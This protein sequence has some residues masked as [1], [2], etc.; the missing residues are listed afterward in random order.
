[1]MKIELR[2]DKVYLDGY[3]NAVGRDSRPIPDRRGP[4]VEQVVPGTFEKALSRGKPIELRIN[5]GRALGSTADG[6]LELYEDSIGLRA[7]AQVT[8]AEVIA[9]ARKKE[10]RGWSF[11]FK[12]VKDSWEERENAPPRRY[13][14]DIDLREVSIIDSKKTPAY[15]ATSIEMRD[16]EEL[17][18]CRAGSDGEPEYTEPVDDDPAAGAGSGEERTAPDAK[19]IMAGYMARR[20]KII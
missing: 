7:K 15:V 3:V 16:G 10:L 13:L 5:H 6:T 20:L 19:T 14:E 12:D 1:M 2:G 18:E 9:S 4:F 17:L 8:D 11:G